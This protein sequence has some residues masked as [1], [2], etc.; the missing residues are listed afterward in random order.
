MLREDPT[1]KVLLALV[2]L[3]IVG[4]IGYLDSLR[5]DRVPASDAAPGEAIARE[6]AARKAL[7]YTPAQEFRA[8]GRFLNSQPFTLQS[9]IGKKVILLD[10]WT[11]SCINCQRTTPYL[12]AWWQKYK[13]SGLVI[14]GM[15]TPEFA[16]EREYENVLAAV[17]KFRIQYPVVQ[18]N[19]F[20]TWN[21]YQNRYWPR[22][23][24]I[25]IDGFVVYDHIGEGGYEETE[26]KIQELLVER[27]DALKEN[28]DV[29]T[30]AVSPGDM[31]T[32]EG[33]KIGSPETYFGADRN[34]FLANGEQQQVGV[35]PLTLPERIEPNKLYLEGNWG[36]REEFAH[37]TKAPAK[38]VYKYSAKSVYFVA[39]AERAITIQLLIDGKP[40]SPDFMGGDVASDGTVTVKEDRLYK[41]VENK[42]G[43]GEHTLEIIIPRAGLRAFTFTFG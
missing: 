24:L 27:A 1:K 11:Y 7:R 25:D 41:L 3:I 33:S 39:S 43:Y 6:D 40:I 23:Y 13:D 38:I 17:R 22:K 26:Q 31:V 30:G 34:T 28:L 15:H 8:P 21:A 35:Q 37:V 2:L 20:G 19:D 18:D 42:A 5:A 12:N 16:F 14:I 4:A 9:F 29:P 10:F 36:F 32:M